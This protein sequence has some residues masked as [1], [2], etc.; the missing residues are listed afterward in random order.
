[1]RGK[2]FELDGTTVDATAEAVTQ[3]LAARGFLWLDLDGMD[4][5]SSQLLLQG[6]GQ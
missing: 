1:M 3:R 5:E 4:A 2:L 6:F